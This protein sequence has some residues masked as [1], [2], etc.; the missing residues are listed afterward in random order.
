MIRDGL[1]IREVRTVRLWEVTGYKGFDNCDNK[2]DYNFKE[3]FYFD[4][5]FGK[6]DVKEFLSYLYKKEGCRTVVFEL[7]GGWG[8]Y[9]EGRPNE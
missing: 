5:C 9:L 1:V 3:E 7:D 8:E 6:E 2:D 4:G